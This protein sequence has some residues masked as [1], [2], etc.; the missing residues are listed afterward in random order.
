MN[1]LDNPFQDLI[2]LQVQ[3]DKISE[4]GKEIQSKSDQVEHRKKNL[5]E[6]IVKLENKNIPIPAV[7]FDFLNK[8]MIEKDKRKELWIK[9]QKLEKKEKL[10]NDYSESIGTQAFKNG[11]YKFSESQKNK[12]E[13]LLAEYEIVISD[14]FNILTKRNDVLNE[15]I[16]LLEEIKEK[17]NKISN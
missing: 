16:R 4:Q 7:M 17:I 9:W 2:N 15:E 14:K 10:I 1:T 6:K 12:I 3:L 8:L 11:V 13:I 5:Y